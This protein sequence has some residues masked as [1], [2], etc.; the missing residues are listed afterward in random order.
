MISTKTFK[1]IIVDAKSI[2][3]IGHFEPDADSLATAISIKRTL[4]NNVELFG[5]K[6][7]DLYVEPD[8]IDE[9]YEPIIAGESFKT[10]DDGEIYDL[11]ICVDCPNVSR[12]GKYSVVFLRAKHTM[13]IDH[14]ESNENFAENNF[15]YKSSSSCEVLYVIFKA[16]NVTLGI[17]V[18]KFL[19]AGI[20]TDTVNL[21]QGNVKV[22]SYKIIAEIAERV[23][24]MEALNAIKDH[25]LKNKSKNNLKLL[26]RALHSMQFYLSDRVAIMKLT[27]QDLEDVNAV[28][29]DTLGIVNNAINIKGVNIAILFIKQEDGTYYASLRSKNGVDVSPIATALGGGGS[30]TVAAFSYGQ[31]LSDLKDRLLELCKE[32]LTEDNDGDDLNNLFSD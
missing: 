8:V 26:E 17:D 32:Q 21:T 29:A 12:M 6:K 1:E 20:V 31:N 28:L 30:E 5:N 11:A 3:I 24:D 18:L 16:L 23:G 2:A 25:F 27:K 19:Y 15:I 22:S 9:I 7:I 10:T 13:L 14:H 4:L